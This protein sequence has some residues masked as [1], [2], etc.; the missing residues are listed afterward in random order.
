MAGWAWGLA[1]LLLLAYEGFAL[2]TGRMTLSRWMRNT[3]IRWDFFGPLVGF[4][5]GGLL[6][7]FFWRFCVLLI[8]VTLALTATAGPATCATAG[9]QVSSAPWYLLNNQW[10]K[11][12][13]TVGSQDVVAVSPSAWRT[14][15]TWTRPDDWQVTTYVAAILGWHGGY[16]VPSEFTGLPIPVVGPHKVLTETA[17]T[18]TPT[19]PAPLRYD[20]AYDLWLAGLPDGSGPRVELMVWLSFSQDYLGVNQPY[21][22]YPTIG[23]VKW[24]VFVTATRGPKLDTISFLVNGPNLTGAKLDLKDFVRWTVENRPD[25]LP[26]THFLTG[27]EFGPEIYK[28]AGTLDVTKY[29]VRVE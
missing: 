26:A 23:G 15:F 29:T 17:F 20:V 22:A 14:T 13:A 18:I 8:A 2:A 27:V 11:S 21:V 7:H 1:L 3:Q 5:T 10:G 6:V 25:I 16:Q 9:C 12:P 19:G 28:G 4:I 24:K